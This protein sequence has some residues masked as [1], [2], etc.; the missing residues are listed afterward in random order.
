ML[1]EELPLEVGDFA[2]EGEV[3][4]LFGVDNE[5]ACPSREGEEQGRAQQAEGQEDAHA[6]PRT[7][8]GKGR[9]VIEACERESQ[10]RRRRSEGKGN[11]REDAVLGGVREHA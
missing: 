2:M 10:S 7:R 9:E 11:H 1:P 3:D 6:D 8:A 5:H 4:L